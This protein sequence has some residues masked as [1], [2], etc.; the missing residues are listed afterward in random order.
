M[1]IFLC[2]QGK[3]LVKIS[4]VPQTVLVQAIINLGI[5]YQNNKQIKDSIMNIVRKD[6]HIAYSVVII[7]LNK[8]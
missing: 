5:N 2:D 8:V 4:I 7:Y 3:I 6:S 1:Q